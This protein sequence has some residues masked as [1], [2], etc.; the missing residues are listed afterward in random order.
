MPEIFKIASRG[1]KNLKYQN[2][3]PATKIKIAPIPTERILKNA[4]FSPTFFKPNKK[5]IPKA[6]APEE[7]G[8]H[9]RLW[10]QKPHF[11]SKSK[12]HLFLE[13]QLP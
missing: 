4:S 5:Q 7:K 6:A 9:S 11:S 12:F 1:V 2:S 8:I 3:I 13:G 10:S